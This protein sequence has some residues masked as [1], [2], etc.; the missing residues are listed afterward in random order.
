MV[1]EHNRLIVDAY[2]ANPSSMTAA[3]QNFRLIEAPR[4][5]AIL[6]DMRE[7]GEVSLEEH[8]KTV[9]LLAAS[10]LT[11]VWLVGDEF[12]KTTTQFRKFK[13]VEEVKA[14]IQKNRPTGHLILIKGSNGTKLYQLPELL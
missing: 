5:M 14:E 6:G 4:K 2:N 3:L 12:G 7:L 9:D 10:S 13:D 11:N 1:T 8:Q